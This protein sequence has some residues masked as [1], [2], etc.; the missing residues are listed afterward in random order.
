MIAL[1]RLNT[2]RAA[3]AVGA[4]VLLPLSLV[5]CGGIEEPSIDDSASPESLDPVT[6]TETVVDEAEAGDEEE[7]VDDE[8]ADEKVAEEPE[9][10]GSQYVP[11][12][13][14]ECEWQ[15]KSS[16]QPGEVFSEYCDGY[17]AVLAWMNS[18]GQELR[19][20]NGTSWAIME[21]HARDEFAGYGCWDADSLREIGAEESVFDHLSL[22]D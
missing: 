17:Y 11:A 3:A 18:G 5:A 12:T 4:A 16:A 13:K 10:Q 9:D 14:G 21:P 8:P 2:R 19:R 1:P 6:I 7:P 20:W 15:D 22:C